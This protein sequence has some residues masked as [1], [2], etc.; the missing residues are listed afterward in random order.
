M[1]EKIE[2]RRSYYTTHTNTLCEQN[3][4]FSVERGGMQSPLTK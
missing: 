3:S 1:L 2:L 4:A